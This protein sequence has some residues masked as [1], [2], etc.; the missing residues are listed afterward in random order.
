MPSSIVEKE[1]R[2]I[3]SFVRSFDVPS[4]VFREGRKM[5]VISTDLDAVHTRMR[6]RFD[7]EEA[8]TV[9]VVGEG[10]IT[11]VYD[12]PSKYEHYDLMVLEVRETRSE[13]GLEPVVESSDNLRELNSKEIQD[14]DRQLRES[15]MNLDGLTKEL[16]DDL[17]KFQVP[18]RES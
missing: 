2:E 18:D 5:E 16:Y 14:I 17:K 9:A 7:T 10:S 6:E 11:E 13:R 4:I 1:I 12:V 3:E 15:D 8:A